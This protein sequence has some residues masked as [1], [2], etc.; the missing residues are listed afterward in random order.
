LRFLGKEGVLTG[1]EALIGEEGW[2]EG[3]FPG[4]NKGPG[5]VRNWET[6][7]E[8]QRP[9]LKKGGSHGVKGLGRFSGPES[10]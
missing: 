2:E 8:F 5:I 6:L 7:P 4:T 9:S 3:L 1:L 10:F